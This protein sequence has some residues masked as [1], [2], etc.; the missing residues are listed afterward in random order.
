[1]DNVAAIMNVWAKSN[2]IEYFDAGGDEACLIPSSKIKAV[3]AMQQRS[4]DWCF[5]EFAGYFITYH[6]KASWLYLA[7][8]MYLR[9]ANSTA[10]EMINQYL[11]T[12]GNM[13]TLLYQL[14][15]I[16]LVNVVL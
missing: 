10:L 2:W 1:M 16:I 4:M 5:Q 6:P 3:Q 7:S 15:Y 12:K 8:K 13:W 9:G 11:E 14:M